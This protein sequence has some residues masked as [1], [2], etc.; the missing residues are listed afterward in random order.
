MAYTDHWD[1]TDVEE[2]LDAPGGPSDVG[3]PARRWGGV[4]AGLLLA[5]L[6]AGGAL[7][8]GSGGQSMVDA[9]ALSRPVARGQV[10]TAADLAQVRVAADGGAV[11]LATPAMARDLLLGRQALV[12]LP[13]G[14]LVTPELVGS[15]AGPAGTLTLGVAVDPAGLP[16]AAPRPGERVDVV[17]IDPVTKTALTLARGVTVTEVRRPSGASGT[18]ETVVYLA[19]PADLAARVATVAAVSPGVR[20]LG[21]TGAGSPGVAVDGS[22]STGEAATGPGPATTAGPSAGAVGGA[23]RS[24]SATPA[25]M[26][27]GTTGGSGIGGDG[28]AGTV[29]GGR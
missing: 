15:V 21:A 20:L 1:D 12:D 11:R 26:P 17:G 6:G 4:L 14:T 27:G 3:R 28:L 10:V 8:L 19:V 9:V 5:V 18:G 29:G 7:W 13:A 2:S 25:G 24:P 16:S 23:T 22:A